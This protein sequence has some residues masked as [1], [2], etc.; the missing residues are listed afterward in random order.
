MTLSPPDTRNGANDP[1]GVGQT[2]HR[3]LM[4]A[5]ALMGTGALFPNVIL[6]DGRAVDA[7]P[8]AADQAAPAI[9]RRAPAHA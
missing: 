8:P 5:G 2:L 7:A 1:H 4:A 3:W 6:P 9:G